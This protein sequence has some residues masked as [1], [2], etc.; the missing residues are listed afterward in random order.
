MLDNSSGKR[1][2]QK[3]SP[4]PDRVELDNDCRATIFTGFTIFTDFTDA[5][6][7]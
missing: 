5:G 2:I 3:S 7:F 1:H 6:Y 4:E